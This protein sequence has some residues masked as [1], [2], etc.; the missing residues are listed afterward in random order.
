MDGKVRKLSHRINMLDVA[1]VWCVHKPSGQ[2]K[3]IYYQTYI[4]T[5]YTLPVSVSIPLLK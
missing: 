1:L 3:P 4:H 2:V 5:L